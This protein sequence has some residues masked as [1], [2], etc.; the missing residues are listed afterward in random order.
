M[1]I[2]TPNA[3]GIDLN[4]P[5]DYLHSLHQPFHTRL[6]SDRA[7]TA[8]AEETGF[9][10]LHLY[11]RRY[12][13]TP[14]PFMNYTFLLDYLK[15]YDNTF[16]ACGDKKSLTLLFTRPSLLFYGFFGYFFPNRGEMMLLVRR[17]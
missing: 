13:G 12:F 1:L 2:T 15:A 8:M 14:E 4:K 5:E 6:F 17:K 9:E 3:A 11:R 16:D 7:L 10:V